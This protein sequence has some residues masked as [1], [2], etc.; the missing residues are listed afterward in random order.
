[1]EPRA[2]SRDLRALARGFRRGGP[3]TFER[4]WKVLSRKGLPLIERLPGDSHQLLVTFVW[5]PSRPVARPSVYTPVVDFSEHQTE[6]I[7]LQGTGVWY[8]SIRLSRGTRA[9]YAFSPLP[10]PGLNEGEGAWSR[11]LRST[12]PDPFNP[13]RIVFDRDPDVPKDIPLTLSVVELPGAP[14]QP[15]AR[16]RGSSEWREEQLRIRSKILGNERP[17]W[18]ILPPTFRRGSGRY[19]L[20]VVFDGFTFRSSIPT[21]RI[22][23]NLVA[24][25]RIG[26]TVVLLVGHAGNSRTKELWLNPRYADFLARELLPWLRRKYKFP[27]VGAR[28]VLAGSSLG[29]LASAYAALRYPGLFGN[30]LAMS[31]AFMASQP[32]DAKGPGALMRAYARA[33]KLPLRFYL[34]CG[35]KETMVFP[36]SGM[37]LLGSVRHMRDVL[38]AKGYPVS[39][40]EFEGGHDYVCWRSSIADGL[41]QLLGRP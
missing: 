32:R 14:R 35:S 41:I 4:D 16:L 8:R 25:G 10:I 40:V 1:M 9:S 2:E 18:V 27:V 28:T 19:N 17:V 5:R 29:G 12:R 3:R 21:P 31:G 30:V 38:E 26:P 22:V 24:A 36:G 34:D 23:E 39:F 37:T 33:P 15:W 6:L 20:L 13:E 11:Y 7:S